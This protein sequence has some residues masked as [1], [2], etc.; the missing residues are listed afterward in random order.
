MAT[1]VHAPRRRTVRVMAVFVALLVLIM[2]VAV[3]RRMSVDVPNVLA[4]TLPP[5]S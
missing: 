5:D 2:V 3:A 4:G 1:V